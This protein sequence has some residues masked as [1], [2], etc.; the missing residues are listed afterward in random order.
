MDTFMD[1]L[2][3]RLN[4]QE[5]IDAN[6]AADV[7][8]LNKLRGRIKEYDE[9][10]EQMR[11]INQELCAVNEQMSRL[12]GDTI[13]PE[14]QRLVESSIAKI[15]GVQV[16]VSGIDDLVQESRE[17]LQTIRDMGSIQLQRAAD[18]SGSQL[19]KLAEESN[20]Q[21]R[22]LVQ[23]NTLQFQKYADESDAQ[24]QRAA[25][26]SGA[27]LQHMA[28]ESTAQMKKVAV[29]ANAQMQQ[30]MAENAS[31]LQKVMEDSSMKVQR[32][33]EES[34]RKL[35]E[36]QQQGQDTEELKQIMQEKLENTNDCV[37]RECVKV[38]RNVQ[39]VVLEESGKQAESL[40]ES[41]RS[42][43]A[44]LTKIMGLSAAAVVFSL[45]SAAIQ[46]L[47]MLHII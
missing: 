32:V 9:C 17:Q 18:E 27:R 42:T 41:S 12:V 22:K 21:I 47:S 46:I 30:N 43:K 19:Q 34:L 36:F 4:A 31:K 1:K 33:S 13:T 7:E 25:E 44:I 40:S 24:M 16:N 10:L 45:I 3:Q 38:Y 6:S 26:E 15:E 2:A 39:A 37:H 8:E 35:R 23:E 28:E 20:A 5:M 14:L 11:E 29:E